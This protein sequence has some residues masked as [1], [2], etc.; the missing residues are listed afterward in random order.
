M[1]CKKSEKEETMTAK[2]ENDYMGKCSPCGGDL[3]R[4]KVTYIPNYQRDS[5]TRLEKLQCMFLF[6]SATFSLLIQD[7][8]P[9]INELEPPKE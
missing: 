1:V 7:F 4:T 6:C 8:A 3:R 9:L 2:L 5:W